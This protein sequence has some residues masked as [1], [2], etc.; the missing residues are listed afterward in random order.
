MVES[1]V[2][3]PHEND[4][5]CNGSSV[6]CKESDV[7]GSRRVVNST[8]IVMSDLTHSIFLLATLGRKKFAQLFQPGRKLDSIPAILLEK[9]DSDRGN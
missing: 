5:D 3:L 6:G 1:S 2:V 7:D 9:L 8:V 4:V